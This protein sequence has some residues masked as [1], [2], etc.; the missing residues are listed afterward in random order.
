M[1][2]HALVFIL[3][4]ITGCSES[5]SSSEA[6]SDQFLG[7]MEASS[8]VQLDLFDADLEPDTSTPDAMI[9]GARPSILPLDGEPNLPGAT[10][11]TNPVSIGTARAGR[12]NADEERLQGPEA[13]CRVGDFRLDNAKISICIQ[14]ETTFSQF[15]F[16]GGNIVDAHLADR[17]GTDAFREVFVAPGLGEARVDTIGIVKDGSEGG[18]AV[19]RTEGFA[20]GALILQGVLP[21][22][23]LPPASYITTEY[24]LEPDSN[25][26]EILTWIHIRETFAVNL[27]L[28]DF[29]YFGDRTALFT[30][31]NVLGEFPNKM[32]YVAATAKDVSY[33]WETDFA[34]F[35][36]YVVSALGLPGA[37][38]T[39]DSETLN[40][41]D[42]RLYQRRLVVGG[43]DVESL[44]T[45]DDD[46]IEVQFQGRSNTQ[47]V[48]TTQEAKAVTTLLLDADGR[49]TAQ[50]LADTYQVR[51]WPLHQ[52]AYEESFTVSQDNTEVTL[53]QAV[54]G[55]LSISIRNEANQPIDGM[56][57]LTG[58]RNQVHFVLGDHTLDLSE[59]EWRATISRGW[60]YNV[61]TE[62]FTIQ[63]GENLSKSYTLIEE[64]PLSGFA[65]GEFHQHASPSLDSDVAVEERVKSNLAAGV[66]FM[67]PSD[68][69]IIYPY[70]QLIDRMGVGERIG[71][72]LTGEEISPLVT[73]IG[74]YGIPYDPY[75]GAG[76]ALRIPV[77]TEDGRWRV[78]DVPELIAAARDKGAQIIQI[79]HPRASQGYFDHVEYSPEIPIE[80]LDSQIF[81][82]DFDTLEIF[83]SPNY[84][85]RNFQ[86]WQGLLNQGLRVTA[87]GN[88]DTHSRDKVPGYPRNYLRTLA[89]NPINVTAAEISDSI[90]Q[91]AV[92]MGGGAMM[93]FPAGPQPGD[94]IALMDEAI[95]LNVRV[96]TPSFAK[97]DRIMVI[98][99]G[100]VIMDQS[101]DTV[102]QDLVDFDERLTLNFSEDAHVTVLALGNQPLTVVRP[103]GPVFAMSNPIWVDVDDD[104]ISLP[105]P[106]EVPSLGLFFCSQ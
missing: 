22:A 51:N 102:A 5:T 36:F 84:F 76:G 3:L 97:V 41:D 44:R 9:T 100:I 23:F 1:K 90:T 70:Q 63:S 43:G 56:L 106:R 95:T 80:T 2:F 68:H 72:P 8:D 88:S 82:T 40:A 57:R 73:H 71:A 24:R 34:P 77:T 27:R 15:S 19:I 25:A 33:A 65:S 75:A 98:A 99:N 94:T 31:D 42:I 85:C 55:S 83:N 74:A 18:H 93:D 48:I 10:M 79:N 61:E 39:S 11:L 64:I 49:G 78:M 105:G 6:S 4:T 92:T 16:F 45:P 32:P 101:I 66:D 47:I 14:A 37:P 54:P 67:V 58:P 91:G 21:N 62:T 26:V 29:V 13:N 30:P 87:I 38:I 96:Q 89:P 59:G 53:T 81:S 86:D 20:Q 46:A 28:V 17:P 52:T 60:H 35:S 7:D 104:G 12:V 103:G 50:L 69:D